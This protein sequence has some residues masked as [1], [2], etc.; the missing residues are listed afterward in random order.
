MADNFDHKAIES[1]WQE[2]WDKSKEHY[3]DLSDDKDKLYVLVMF[4]YPSGDKLH[5]GH[6]YNYGPTDSWARFKKLHGFKVFEPMGFDSFG[7]PA[8][9]Y[10]I[11]NGVHPAV[12]TKKNIKYMT[13]QLHRIGAMYDWDKYLSTSDPEYYKWTQWLFLKLYDMGL[14]YKE[15]A[16]VNWC[17]S[18]LTVLAN[19]QVIEGHCERCETEV[20]KK[21]LSQW[22]FRIT[23]YAEELLD[24]LENINWPESTKLMQKNWIGRSEGTT[25]FFEIADTEEKLNIFTTRVDT[26]YGAT[27]IIVAP[28]HHILEHIVSDEKREEVNAYVEKAKNTSEIERSTLERDKT[29]VFTGAYGINPIT[30]DKLPVWTSDFVLVTYGSGAIFGTP[31]HDKRDWEFATKFELPI[32]QVI[33]PSDNEPVDLKK[34]VCSGDGVLINSGGE[35]IQ[36]F[37]C[38]GYLEKHCGPFRPSSPVFLHQFR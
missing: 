7:L 14:A 17:P 35:Y 27:F 5:V 22:F 25:V 19:E 13:K 12:S 4:S 32:K 38:I 24:G 33:E 30:G 11:K 3:V 31:G 6:W 15:V 9:N 29:G 36:F 16:P 23:K 28:E 2:I 18:C 1:K 20:E 10:A 37:F 21:D 26:I 34:D 8:E